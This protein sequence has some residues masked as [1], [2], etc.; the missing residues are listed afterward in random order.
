MYS[1]QRLKHNLPKVGDLTEWA[2]K[3]IPGWTLSLNSWIHIQP[4]EI[5]YGVRNFS[6]YCK[7]IC[8]MKKTQHFGQNLLTIKMHLHT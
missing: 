1:T 6:K 8:I 5:N 4:Q 2:S 7:H 3:Y